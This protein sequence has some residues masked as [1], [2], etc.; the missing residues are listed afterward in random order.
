MAMVL[1]AGAVMVMPVSAGQTVEHTASFDVFS[2]GEYISNADE[3]RVLG[4]VEERQGNYVDQIYLKVEA[5]NA[6]YPFGPWDKYAY[7]NWQTSLGWH[8]CQDPNHAQRNHDVI[9][10]FSSCGESEEARY[11]LRAN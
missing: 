2:I 9:T 8:T 3:F 7:N 1:V 4:K 5:T 10:S 6:P 11:T